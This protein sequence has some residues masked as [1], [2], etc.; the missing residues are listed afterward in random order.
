MPGDRGRI[1][2]VRAQLVQIFR[3]VTES[4]T[5]WKASERI[6]ELLEHNMIE[7]APSKELDSIYES[8]LSEGSDTTALLSTSQVPEVVN[9][10][11][12]PETA[13]ADLLRALEQ[14]KLRLKGGSESS[15][16]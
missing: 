7:T 14:V 9:L 4:T 12:L 5:A 13:S 1:T 3:R 10:F 15:D 6:E 16:K 11:G 8:A 2:E